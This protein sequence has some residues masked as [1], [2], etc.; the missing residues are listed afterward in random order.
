MV[1]TLV[2]LAVLD[3]L[4]ATHMPV[5]GRVGMVVT[6]IIPGL[7]IALLGLHYAITLAPQA[8]AAENLYF[9]WLGIA[10]AGSLMVPLMG[11]GVLIAGLIHSTRRLDLW[12]RP[13]VTP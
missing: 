2:A 11:W 13:P 4:L 8:S 1:V 9:G 7:A 12:R 5:I 3:A 10:V 6:W